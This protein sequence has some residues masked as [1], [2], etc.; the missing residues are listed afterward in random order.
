MQKIQQT[1]NGGNA[2][3]EGDYSNA[4][5]G[6]GGDSSRGPGGSGGYAH[7]VGTNSTAIGGGGG[8]GGLGPGGPGGEAVALGDGDTYYGGDGGESNQADGRGGRGATNQMLHT[9][10]GTEYARRASLKLPYDASNNLLGRGGDTPDTPQYKARRLI[11][12]QIKEAYFVQHGV[13][14]EG[15]AIGSVDP[16]L[17][18][19]DWM[20]AFTAKNCDVWYDREIVP[21]TW[22]NEKV[23][24]GGTKWTVT[25][26]ADEYVFS[27]RSITF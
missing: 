9:V 4:E 11:V 15:A 18:D 22:I 13:P 8:R 20:L 5:G 2:H 21:L 26:E 24:Q 23:H 3:A 14:T 16:R 17:A 10:F 6:I 12:E 25:V 1:A 19:G 27:D 7:A